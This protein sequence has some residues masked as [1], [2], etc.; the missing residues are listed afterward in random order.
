MTK[1]I[2]LRDDQSNDSVTYHN[3][4]NIKSTCYLSSRLHSLLAHQAFLHARW[5]QG[6]GSHVT[7]W[8]KQHVTPHVGTNHT[9][10][11]PLILVDIRQGDC[12]VL[13]RAPAKQRWQGF[14]KLKSLVLSRT[15]VL[16]FSK[17]K[18]ERKRSGCVAKQNSVMSKTG[19]T[20][21]IYIMVLFLAPL[22]K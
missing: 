17:P 3:S 21:A 6:T 14:R 10:L 2:L 11:Q 18:R 7:T 8:S 20:R 16:S 15:P 4:G 9:F 22:F 12:V 19:F 13:L 1:K 5:A